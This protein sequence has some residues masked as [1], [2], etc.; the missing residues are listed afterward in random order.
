MIDDPRLF[1]LR[2]ALESRPA[3]QLPRRPES[4]EAAV[5]LVLRPGVDLELLLIKRAEHEADPWSGQMA[6]PGGRRSAQDRD[7]SE[8]ALR[9][10]EEETGVVVTR[11][12]ALLGA[13]DEVAPGS[14]RLPPVLIAPFVATV[15]AATL[16][17][18]DP[19]EVAA[20]L[21]IPLPALRAPG[22]AGEILV[23]LEGGRRAF[24]ALHYGPHV[25]WGLTHRIL[26]QFLELAA[27]AG[28]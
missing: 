3:R 15:P 14:A 24:P 20:A 9:E 16:T 4:R 10:T 7:L 21:W 19:R 6:L 2:R 18:P 22:A 5:A 23:E 17:H 26:T 28:V 27:E 13:L 8:T 11:G 1:L 25:I 12:G